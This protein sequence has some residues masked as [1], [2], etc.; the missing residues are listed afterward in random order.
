MIYED[1][2]NFN[3]FINLLND[4]NIKNNQPQNIKLKLKPHQLT[5]LYYMKEIERTNEIKFN[6]NNNI[7]YILQTNIG[8][9]G[10]DVGYGK[11]LTALSIL[12]HNNIKKDN[13]EFLLHTDNT[14]LIRKEKIDYLDL[15]IIV[16]PH[17]IYFQWKNTINK[18]TSY[19]FNFINKKKDIELFKNQIKKNLLISSTMFNYFIGQTKIKCIKRLIID[20]GDTINIPNMREIKSYFVWFLSGTSVYTRFKYPSNYGFIRNK[21]YNINYNVFN[22]LIVKNHINYIKQSFHM[23]DYLVKSY[24]CIPTYNLNGLNNILSKSILEMINA[25]NY[26]GALE[27]LGGKS[28]SE[29]DIVKLV[30]LDINRKLNNKKNKLLYIKSLEINELEKKEKLLKIDEEINSY[31]IQ[32]EGIKDRILNI[33][34]KICPICMDTYKEPITLECTHVFCS[35]CFFE[36]INCGKIPKCPTCRKCINLENIIKV[37]N[38]NL[39]NN[40]NNILSKNETI[41]KILNE[42]RNK[43]F[44]IFSNWYNSFNLLLD[45]L[46]NEKISYSFLKGTN[47]TIANKINKFNEGNINLLFLNSKYSG[48]G[49]D[50]S[51]ADNIILYHRLNKE[52]EKQ[53]IGRAYRIGR[54][55]SLIVH[56]LYNVNE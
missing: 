54:E 17:N 4:T 6:S 1:N 41:I 50:L 14:L 2:N 35:I 21:F 7:N 26:L 15:N 33:D 29:D 32:L 34:N 56:Q 53:V 24:K 11:T 19:D 16:I 45:K 27:L 8:I 47:Y 25:N 40:N 52:V 48:T 46:D 36:C 55:T 5:A 51:K 22:L 43:K 20:E 30:S 3:F 49:I 12:E 42:N 18:Y 10:D 31:E 9:L 44:I 38:N 39:K 28:E 13:Q 23:E 37:S